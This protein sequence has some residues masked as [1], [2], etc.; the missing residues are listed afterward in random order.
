ML[1]RPTADPAIAMIAAK[2]LLNLPLLLTLQF[3]KE[4]GHAAGDV[5]DDALQLL[6]GLEH[7][8]ALTGQIQIALGDALVF[9]NRAEVRGAETVQLAPQLCDPPEAQSS[10][11]GF[12][13]ML[14]TSLFCTFLS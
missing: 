1:P 13:P 2:W 8:V 4:I 14:K 7:V 10:T 3:F 11:Q 5:A 6:F 12:K 9:V